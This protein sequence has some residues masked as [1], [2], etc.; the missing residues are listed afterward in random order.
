ML[1]TFN[2]DGNGRQIDAAA[3]FFRYEA[4]DAGGAALEIRVTAD[5]QDLGSYLP[6]DA[7]RLPPGVP[8][9]TRWVFTPASA[10]LAATV[11]LGRAEVE[12]ARLVGSVNVIDGNARKTQGGTQFYATLVKGAIAGKV[13]MIGLQ[14]VTK[15]LAIKRLALYSAAGGN[16]AIWQ[17]TGAPTD[18]PSSSSL[19]NKLNLTASSDS[20]RVAGE[21]TTTTPSGAELPGGSRMFFV[22]LAPG[23]AF[24]LPLTTPFV[25][26]PGRLLVV[27][28]A[29][30]NVDLTYNADCEEL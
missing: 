28:G 18:V 4:G 15:S 16:C 13:S 23:V 22:L 29:A 30:V 6:G 1:Q 20:R 3:R 19:L 14:A 2:I 9:A 8:E 11:R 10:A 25:I 24:E 17:A 27:V 7:V 26:T 12:S 5:G 21:A